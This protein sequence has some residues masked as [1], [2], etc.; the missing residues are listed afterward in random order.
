MSDFKIFELTGQSALG[1]H[2]YKVRA[3]SPA[4]AMGMC[5]AAL[6]DSR[7]GLYVRNWDVAE[8]RTQCF[9]HEG[10]D[11]ADDTHGAVEL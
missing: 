1:T 4:Q 8:V 3:T 5:D 7:P 10:C 9:T 6:S 2:K 11:G